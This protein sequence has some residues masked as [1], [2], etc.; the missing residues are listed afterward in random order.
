M[1]EDEFQEMMKQFLEN[2]DYDQMTRL[3]KVLTMFAYAEEFRWW[4]PPLFS[5]TMI[6]LFIAMFIYHVCYLYSITGFY[7]KLAKCSKWILNPNRRWEWWRFFTYAFVHNGPGHLITNLMT[8]LFIG[9]PLELTNKWWRVAIVFFTSIIGGSI[10]VSVFDPATQLV[11]ASGGVYGLLGAHAAHLILNWKED[12]LIMQ[13]EIE[14]HKRTRAI[15]AKAIR[16]GR[17]V[18]VLLLGT[19]DMVVSIVSK[20]KY[21]DNSVSL[22]AHLGGGLT[23]LVIGIMVMKDRK[24][25]FWE[26]CLKGTVIF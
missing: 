5:T 7:Y 13:Q 12:N 16:T 1:T 24:P 9:L 17:L 3:R 18:V 8:I 15:K 19:V 6:L 11:G 23:G 20:Y 25:E 10:T 14:R 2:S 22:L 4:P 26:R 21:N